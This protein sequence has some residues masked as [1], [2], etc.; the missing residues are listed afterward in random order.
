MKALIVIAACAALA[1]LAAAQRQ[2]QPNPADPAV[3]VPSM[4]YESAFAGYISYR[5]QD[6]APWR[7]VNDEVARTGGHTGI[8]GGARDSGHA[9][10]KPAAKSPATSPAPISIPAPKAAGH[11]A[12]HK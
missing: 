3:R 10:A 8:F 6:V 2:P 7:D 12:D 4:N 1:P 5:Q 9:P 11:G